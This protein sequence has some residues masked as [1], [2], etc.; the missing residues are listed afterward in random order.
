MKKILFL[1]LVSAFVNLLAVDPALDRKSAFYVQFGYGN[2]SPGSVKNFFSLQQSSNYNSLFNLPYPTSHP[3]KFNVANSLGTSAAKNLGFGFIFGSKSGGHR[4]NLSFNMLYT[5]DN[6]FGNPYYS[7]L[8]SASETELGVQVFSLNPIQKGSVQYDHDFYLI[9]DHKSKWVSGIGLKLGALAQ[10]DTFSGNFTPYTATNS[11]TASSQ[12]ADLRIPIKYDVNYRDPSALG[13]LGLV[14]RLALFPNHEFELGA[15]YYYGRS[16]TRFTLANLSMITLGEYRIP[17]QN[18]YEYKANT[19]IEG[20]AYIF[21]YTYKI[22]HSRS[23]NFFYNLRDLMQT[24]TKLETRISGA[25]P[26]FGA[27][28]PFQGVRDRSSTFGFQFQVRY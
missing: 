9:P 1:F 2:W 5:G 11:I 3:L 27:S 24:P 15:N 7:K 4:G 17:F 6:H 23:I 28:G 14:Y 18:D 19:D 16:K 20:M 8:A 22:S 26:I 25:S 21:G 12:V 13:I 10:Y